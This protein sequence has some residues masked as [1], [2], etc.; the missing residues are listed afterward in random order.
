MRQ[1]CVGDMNLVGPRPALYNQHGLIALRTER[2][3]HQ[4]LPGLT[5]WAQVNGRDELPIPRKVEFDV[6]YMQR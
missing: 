1:G 6:E 2:G 5:G 3:V 4:L